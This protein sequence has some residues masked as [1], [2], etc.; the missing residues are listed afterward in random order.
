MFEGMTYKGAAD[1]LRRLKSTGEPRWSELE[2]K[3]L[4]EALDIAIKLLD[5]TAKQQN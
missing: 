4:D 5:E 1:T 3:K 2:G